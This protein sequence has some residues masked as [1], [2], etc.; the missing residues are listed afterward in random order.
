MTGTLVAALLA[1]QAAGP[2]LTLENALKDA[3]ERKKNESLR[4]VPTS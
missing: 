2:L 4:P 1:V 3:R